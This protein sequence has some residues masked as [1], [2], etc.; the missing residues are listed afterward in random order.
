MI[1]AILFDI[2]GVLIENPP[3][4]IYRGYAELRHESPETIRKKLRRILIPCEIGK[5]SSEEFWS[6]GARKF[7]LKKKL[8][9]KVWIEGIKSSKPHKMVWRLVK[10]LKS[11]GYKLVLLTNAIPADAKIP[12]IK[13][14]YSKFYPNV[15]ASFRLGCKKPSEKIYRLVLK[16]LKLRPKEVVFID[17]L[18]KNA[19][20]ARR[21]GMIGLHFTSY[22]KLASDLKKLKV[23]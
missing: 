23:L 10:R 19:E 17:N 14:I 6:K 12:L 21:V 15:F 7:G 11:K 9:R 8:F 5:I 1:K 16:K 4:K 13:R 3:D 20:G 18:E 2:G 22:K